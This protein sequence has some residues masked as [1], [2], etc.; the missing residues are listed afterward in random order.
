MP[1][2]PL[3]RRGG[4]GSDDEHPKNSIASPTGSRI[5]LFTTI[6]FVLI[7]MQ[8]YPHLFNNFSRLKPK[9]IKP[10]TKKMTAPT[11]QVI[12]LAVN[13]VNDYPFIEHNCAVISRTNHQYYVYTDDFSQPACKKC[14]CV[15][16]VPSNCKCR[17]EGHR[18][19]FFCEKLDFYVSQLKLR[20][21]LVFLDSD[22]IILRDDFLDKLAFRSII[23][24]FLASYVPTKRV[25]TDFYANINS[26][27]FFMRWLPNVDYTAMRGTMIARGMLGDQNALGKFVQTTYKSWDTLSVRWHCRLLK[28]EG[29]NIP[30]EECFTH[31]DDIERVPFLRSLNRT[32]ETI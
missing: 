18:A 11:L 21:E 10:T 31:H 20:K 19:C 14:H 4:R 27:L 24:D 28:R 6:V 1:A 22:L 25:L 29:Y 13:R 5:L 30:P 8:Y 16:F 3:S 2:T 12:T 15:K 32:L 17:R 26:G 7:L 23:A 9:L